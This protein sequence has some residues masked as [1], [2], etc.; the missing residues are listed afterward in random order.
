MPA[1][2]SASSA[3][4]SVLGLLVGVILTLELIRFEI[5]PGGGAL[6]VF[7]SKYNSQ[8]GHE[9]PTPTTALKSNT[10]HDTSKLPARNNAPILNDFEKSKEFRG[11]RKTYRPKREGDMNPIPGVQPLEKVVGKTPDPNQLLSNNGEYS[12]TKDCKY[13]FK[14]FVYPLPGHI[15]PVRLAEEARRNRTLH[16]C[17]K[18]ILEQ[19]SLEYVV[20]DF[21]TQFCGRTQ[22]PEEADFLTPNS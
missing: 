15:P 1:L 3:G 5:L 2:S 18:C 7:K 12:R 9:R 22:N 8:V 16:I 4:I 10:E 20:T 21:L 14:V 13:D 6:D 17:Q 11:L 19:F